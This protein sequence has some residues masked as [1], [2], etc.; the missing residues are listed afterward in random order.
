[1]FTHWVFIKYFFFLG[2][3][4]FSASAVSAPKETSNTPKE[5]PSTVFQRQRV[6]MLLAELVRQ[7]P[8]PVAPAAHNQVKSNIYL[9]LI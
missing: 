5:E 1:M 2:L 8:L 6:D 3:S 7:F 9:F 4:P